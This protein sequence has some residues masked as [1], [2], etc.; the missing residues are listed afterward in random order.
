[1]KKLVIVALVAVFCISSCQPVKTNY[2]TSVDIHNTN[3]NIDYVSVKFPNG[4][5]SI[6][7]RSVEDMDNLISQ[8]DLL[9]Q[10]LKDARAQM[11]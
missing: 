10:Q 6:T 1:M 3:G 5:S 9:Q 4:S 7:V 8:V 11:K 2:A